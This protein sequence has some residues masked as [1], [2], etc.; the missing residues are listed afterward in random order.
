MSKQ[1]DLGVVLPILKGDW[2]SGTAYERLNIVRYN[3]AAWVCN[4]NLI[5]QDEVELP[6]GTANSTGKQNWVV[7]AEDTSA[8]ASV[9]GA[10]G[11]VTINTIETPSD[12]SNDKSI[13]NTT[14][15]RDRIDEAIESVSDDT[16]VALAGISASLDNKLDKSGG[17]MTGIITVSDTDDI[18]KRDVND[19]R[20]VLLGG[21]NWQK[22]SMLELYGG[23]NS[24]HVTISAKDGTNGSHF[25]L[26]PTGTAQING[27]TVL[28]SAGGTLNGGL[29]FNVAEQSGINIITTNRDNGYVQI[30]G[31]TA[32][33]GGAA[34]TLHG[35]SRTEKPGWVEFRAT[36][37]TNAA[38][39]V[40]KPDGSLLKSGNN[41]ATFNSSNRLLFP[42][43][44]QF[45][46]A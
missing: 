44:T 5:P 42:N 26:Y 36:D 13:A 14:W 8:V 35:K 1:I 17:T 20:L 32:W 22:C 39:L 24:G 40:L 33:S 28:T 38:S 19:A 41:V 18:I 6:P 3:S 10:T 30:C 23:D 9:N 31:S 12:D 21:N 15:V 46:I 2:V 37:G 43:G 29:K 16:T 45:W 4:V 11:H 25:I 27:N 34:C 7:L